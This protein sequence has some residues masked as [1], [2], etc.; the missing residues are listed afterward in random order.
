MVLAVIAT[1]ALACRAQ[2]NGSSV[3]QHFDRLARVERATQAYDDGARAAVIAATYDEM[4]RRVRDTHALEQAD[5]HDL[6]LLYRAARLAAFHSHGPRH[7]QDMTSFLSGLQRRGLAS[8]R[9]YRHMHEAFVGARMFAEARN[10]ATQHP[11]EV[12]ERLPVL[13]EAA[14]L[15]AGQPT[16]LVVHPDQHELLRRSA[17]LRRPSQVV[18]VSHPRCHFSRAAMQDI[19]ADPVLGRILATHARWLAPQ[20]DDLDFD[21]LQQWNREH[22]EQQITLTFRRDEWPMI[23]SWQTPTFYFLEDGVVI[24]KLDGWPQHGRRAE[25]LAALRQIG[26]LP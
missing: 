6:E 8:S 14:D 18:V 22:V 4:V 9:H 20:D 25:L 19:R 10:L 26:L 13:R 11:T 2:T 15:V 5:G 16:E 7:V 12:L 23:D 24:A 3:E 21:V 17:D 1:Q